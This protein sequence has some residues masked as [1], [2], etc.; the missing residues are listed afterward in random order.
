MVVDNKE[1][2][3]PE[4]RKLRGRGGF[5]FFLSLTEVPRKTKMTKTQRTKSI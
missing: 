5:F 3:K 1:K 4:D 2:V